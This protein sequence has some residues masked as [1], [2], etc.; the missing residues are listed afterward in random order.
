LSTDL[1][2]DVPKGSA[3]SPVASRVPVS[4]EA[5][6]PICRVVEV[7]F[8]QLVASELCVPIWCVMFRRV[9]DPSGAAFGLLVSSE[10]CVPI[11]C[12]MLRRDAFGIHRLFQTRSVFLTEGSCWF[13][14][15]HLRKRQPSRW[16]TQTQR[17]PMTTETVTTFFAFLSIAIHVV[18]ALSIVSYVFSIRTRNQL[19][20]AVGP[21]ALAASAA[22]A[23]I[24]TLG[25]LYLSEVAH[26][27]PCKLCWYQR[28]AMYPLAVLLPIAALRSDRAIRPYATALGG[29][30]VIIALYHVVLERFPNLESSTCDPANPCSLKWVDKFGYITIPV[31]ALTGFISILL[32]LRVHTIY[33]RQLALSSSGV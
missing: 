9:A 7:A 4:S 16:Q 27:L 2:R 20:A 26:F 31:M 1:V 10:V 3:I 17:A 25:S 5:C 11:W 19:V 22:I 12:V 23:I 29:V 6:L 18:V 8:G 21:M 32:L 24:C 15:V 28:T 30:G 33:E 14:K 13:G